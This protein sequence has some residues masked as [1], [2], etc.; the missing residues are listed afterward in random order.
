MSYGINI[1]STKPTKIPKNLPFVGKWKII[2]QT[3]YFEGKDWQI[4][5]ANS[6]KLLEEDIPKKILSQ[7]PN[8]KFLT[9][10]SLEPIG[11][12]NS[13]YVKLTQIM[14]HI[15]RESNGIVEDIQSDKIYLPT[16]VSKYISTKS[17]KEER[18]STLVFTWLFT[19]SPLLE[20]DGVNKFVKL[21]EKYL[22]EALPRRY[23][24][25]TPPE[26]KLVEKG[27]K[28]FIEFL[29]K[30]KNNYPVWYHAHPVVSVSVNFNEQWGFRRNVNSKNFYANYVKV[31][32]DSE[33][34][35]QPG[36][37]EHLMI[38]WKNISIFIKPFYGDVRCLNNQIR[39]GTTYLID[40]KSE[41]HPINGGAWKGIPK[42]LGQAIVIGQPYNHLWNKI[43]EKGIK[44][45]GLYFV[46]TQDWQKREELVTILGKVPRD[47]AQFE[48]SFI[49]KMLGKEYNQVK[50][51]KVFPFTKEI[52]IYSLM[53]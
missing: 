26:F 29:E 27:T 13:A 17:G 19:E 30:N 48:P 53:N 52:N 6:T 10:I 15:G 3:A 2:K 12:P 43:K 36:W 38:F 22:P 21:L 16:G 32:I 4:I 23:G 39:G 14:K 20:K 41:R 42:S 28:H 51:P 40:A 25:H 50:Y 7:L 9:E 18:F 1:W 24:S 49:H 11:A 5:V 35:N 46:S 8:I 37:K 47:I 34:L 33:I 45:D 31:D 44:Q